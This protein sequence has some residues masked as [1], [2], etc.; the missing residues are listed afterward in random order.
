MLPCQP[1]DTSVGGGGTLERSTVAVDTLGDCLHRLKASHH[2]SAD[3]S[4]TDR[5]IKE[6]GIPRESLVLASKVFYDTSPNDSAVGS[7]NLRGL[8]RKH[9]FQSVK[10]SLERLGVSSISPPAGK[11][12]DCLPSTLQTDYLDLLQCHRADPDTPIEVRSTFLLPLR[13][14]EIGGSRKRPADVGSTSYRRR[15][16][17]YTM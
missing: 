6:L 2:T 1:T 14:A 12:A 4:D 10:D 7:A 3:P 11:D 17:L 13:L 16:M 8:S 15:W 5:A 9:I